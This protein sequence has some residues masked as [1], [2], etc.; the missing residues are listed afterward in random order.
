MVCLFVGSTARGIGIVVRLQL[1]L[2]SLDGDAPTTKRKAKAAL[3]ML[4]V[5]RDTWLGK[6]VE[7]TSSLADRAERIEEAAQLYLDKKIE[8]HWGAYGPLQ[9]TYYQADTVAGIVHG[10]DLAI[11][12]LEQVIKKGGTE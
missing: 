8:P 12:L 4:K 5:E 2:G 7:I 6:L 11:G 10:L 9:G 3:R 1:E